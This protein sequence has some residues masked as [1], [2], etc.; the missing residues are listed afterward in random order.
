M[1]CKAEAIILNR[2]KGPL[3]VSGI[4]EVVVSNNKQLLLHYTD[5]T[6]VILINVKMWIVL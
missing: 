5:I 1:G 4:T 6:E 2:F 3:K